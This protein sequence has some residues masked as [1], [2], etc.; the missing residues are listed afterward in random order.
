MGP[1]TL[2]ALC[3]PRFIRRGAA[4]CSQH[5]QLA[6]LVKWYLAVSRPPPLLGIAGSIP[7][8]GNGPWQDFLEFRG[9][10]CGHHTCQ[11]RL[12]HCYAGGLR[13]LAVAKDVNLSFFAFPFSACL[14]AFLF[15]SVTPPS[16]AARRATGITTRFHGVLSRPPHFRVVGGKRLPQFISI[17]Y[18]SSWTTSFIIKPAISCSLRRH[19][20]RRLRHVVVFGILAPRPHKIRLCMWIGDP[21]RPFPMGFASRPTHHGCHDAAPQSPCK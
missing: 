5:I 9:V 16:N 11:L 6:S 21:L 13:V 20:A 15:H 7:G 1:A 10:A 12:W 4:L 3:S 18:T 2:S 14:H 19:C 8:V 17:T